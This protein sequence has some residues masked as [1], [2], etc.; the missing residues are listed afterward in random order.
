[1]NLLN[2]ILLLVSDLLEWDCDKQN[3]GYIDVNQHSK[4][5]TNIKSLRQRCQRDIPVAEDW[6]TGLRI[7]IRLTIK[8]IFLQLL[9]LFAIYTPSQSDH[10]DVQVFKIIF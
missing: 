7:L 9:Q 10:F 6:L 3:R 2:F 8:N 5:V 1:M 4:K